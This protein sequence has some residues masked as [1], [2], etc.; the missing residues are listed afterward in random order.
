MFFSCIFILNPRARASKGGWPSMAAR[1]QMIEQGV[2]GGTHLASF[3]HLPCPYLLRALFLTCDCFFCGQ[4]CWVYVTQ[5]HISTVKLWLLG[6]LA[7]QPAGDVV[8]KVADICGA[9]SNLVSC[10][11]PSG[12]LSLQDSTSG[13][14]HMVYLPTSW[15]AR[16]WY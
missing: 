5:T 8:P 3:F 6:P 16:S 13:L 7:V 1:F 10:Q 12:P 9:F 2:A 4:K 11:H 15:Q 14:D